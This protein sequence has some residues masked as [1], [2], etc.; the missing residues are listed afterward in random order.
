M[1][2]EEVYVLLSF[3]LNLEQSAFSMVGTESYFSKEVLF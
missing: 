3:L 2:K 1:T